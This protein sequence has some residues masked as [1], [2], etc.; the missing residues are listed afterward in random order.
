M[1]RLGHSPCM[2]SLYC[3]EAAG[4]FVNCHSTPKHCLSCGL[5][6]WS[7]QTSVQ[8]NNNPSKYSAVIRNYTGTMERTDCEINS[9]SH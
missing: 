5:S 4:F 8:A 6:L 2:M 1:V 9:F 7:S 3:G